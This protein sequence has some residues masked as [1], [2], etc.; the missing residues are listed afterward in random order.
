MSMPQ[1]TQHKS[2]PPALSKRQLDIIADIIRQIPPHLEDTAGLHEADALQATH[3]VAKHFCTRLRGYNS[4]FDRKRFMR[5][6]G[7]E[8]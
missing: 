1:E 6:C 4:N 3:V 5:E 7:L 2:L 8:K